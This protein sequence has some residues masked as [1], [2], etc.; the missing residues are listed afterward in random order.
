[1]SEI[2]FKI[3]NAERVLVENI[4]ERARALDVKVNPDIKRTSLLTWQMDI[5]A[6]H[7]NGCPLDLVKLAQF[8]DADFAHDV[9]GIARHLDRITGELKDCFCPR[10]AL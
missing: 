4:A 5:I 2:S 3:G 6:C 9:F 10:C 1:M 8:G 7:A